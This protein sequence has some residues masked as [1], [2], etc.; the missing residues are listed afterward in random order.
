MN[1]RGGPVATCLHQARPSVSVL[2][3]A[4]RR[5]GEDDDLWHRLAAQRWPAHTLQISPYYKDFRDMMKLDNIYVALPV[6]DLASQGICSTWKYNTPSRF[7]QCRL[8]S[9][10]Y[11]R[12][13]DC[14][15][16]CFDARGEADLRLPATSNIALVQDKLEHEYNP[17]GAQ[18][19][20]A[21][22]LL[23]SSKCD[24]YVYY[25]STEGHF[26]GI[27][28]WTTVQVLPHGPD[29]KY[30]CDTSL[31]FCYASKVVLAPSDDFEAD[32]KTAEILK[33]PAGQSFREALAKQC[34]YDLPYAP[35]ERLKAQTHDE[36]LALWHSLPQAIHDCKSWWEL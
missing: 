2:R 15:R 29:G 12:W 28:H 4:G 14:I 33:I 30:T 6:I 9:F 3:Y 25:V 1:S 23:R 18:Q 19:A 21:N 34:T 13:N 10:Q 5:T 35:E 11:D 27:F 16:L 7:Y 26:Q 20:E 8:V 36:Q 24:K 31:V 32:Y 22:T 17:G